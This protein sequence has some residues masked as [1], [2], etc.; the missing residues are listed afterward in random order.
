[1]SGAGFTQ[2]PP[3]SKVRQ[4]FWL[5]LI[6]IRGYVLLLCVDVNTC[7]LQRQIVQFGLLKLVKGQINVWLS[8]IKIS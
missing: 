6:K 1:M 4:M 3:G 2:L 7:R 5:S 8:L